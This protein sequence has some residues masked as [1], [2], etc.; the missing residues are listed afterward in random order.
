MNQRHLLFFCTAL[1]VPMVAGAF[2]YEPPLG[3]LVLNKPID[4][5]VASTV[6]LRVPRTGH[7]YA[8]LYL[9]TAPGAAESEVTSPFTVALDFTFRSR[10]RVLH[11]EIVNV[12][13]VPG[14]RAKT[15]FWL[16]V[17]NNVPDDR[18]LEVDVAPQSA[19]QRLAWPGSYRLEITRKVEFLPIFAR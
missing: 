16:E 9:E 15:L 5:N 7:Y 11:R 12:T 8:E 1:L 17:P 4:P 6:S 14:D 13:F 18:D 10:T 19:S 3:R 2:H